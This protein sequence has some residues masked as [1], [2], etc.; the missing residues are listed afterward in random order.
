MK[1]TRNTHTYGRVKGVAYKKCDIYPEKDLNNRGLLLK[2][3]ID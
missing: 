3:F 1:L 2:K